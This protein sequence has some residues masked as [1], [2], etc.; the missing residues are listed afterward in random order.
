MIKRWKRMAAVAA[1]LVT[2]V[3]LAQPTA[4]FAATKPY[5]ALGADLNP[6]QRATVLNL[7]GVTEAELAEDTVVTVTNAE[8]HE[9]LDEYVS[10]SLIGTKSLSSCKVVVEP[11]GHGISVETHNISYCTP[12]MYE[13]ALA[14][15]G[16]KNASVTVAGPTSISGTAALVGAMK[17]YSKIYGTVIDPQYLDGATDELVTTGDLAET[18]GDSEKAAELIAAIK[19]IIAEQDIK[20]EQDIYVIIDNISVEMGITLT[21]EQKQQIVDLMKKLAALDLD[22][23]ALTEQAQQ[24][25]ENLKS[26]GLDLSQYGITKEQVNGIWDLL[27]AFFEKLLSLFSRM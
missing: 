9:Y 27:R 1:A 3:T 8:E 12:S 6:E 22:A 17:A 4:A 15:A 26:Q 25:Y 19:Q 13:N 20:S 5:V 24:I 14:T 11:K 21:E 18:L 10:S 16:M 7:L 23:D 2:A